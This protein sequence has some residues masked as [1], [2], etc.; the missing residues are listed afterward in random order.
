MSILQTSSGLRGCAKAARFFPSLL[1]TA[2]LLGACTASNPSGIYYASG[3]E[4]ST[5]DGLHRIKWGTYPVAFV[6]PGVEMEGY[7]ELIIEPLTVSYEKTPTTR[8]A[9]R[10][11]GSYIARDPNYELPEDARKAMGKFY[12]DFLRRR[13]IENCRFDVARKAGEGVLRIRGH[14]SSLTISRPPIVDQ[15]PDGVSLLS[16]SGHMIFSVEVL[17][18]LTG[19]ALLRMA[20]ARQIRGETDYYLSDDFSEVAAIRAI[21]GEWAEDLGRQLDELSALPRIPIPE[22]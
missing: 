18:S 8:V 9:E 11:F 22:S 13:L 14:I 15:P 10:S 16:G 19:Q 7:R 4:I 5:S 3:E 6:R 12:A 2:C 17:N 21:F 20:D 1:A